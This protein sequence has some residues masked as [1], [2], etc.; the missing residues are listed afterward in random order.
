MGECPV[1]ILLI[2]TASLG[3]DVL[4][5]GVALGEDDHGHEIAGLLDLGA[6]APALGGLGVGG[7]GGAQVDAG[8]EDVLDRLDIVGALDLHHRQLTGRGD[9]RRVVEG[10]LGQV[11]IQD[12]WIEVVDEVRVLIGEQDQCLRLLRLRR[13]HRIVEGGEVGPGGRS[14]GLSVAAAGGECEDDGQA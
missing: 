9:H 11:Q 7:V 13:D 6:G 1:L 12:A 8:L 4:R 5:D 14:G 10:R 3:E 2:I